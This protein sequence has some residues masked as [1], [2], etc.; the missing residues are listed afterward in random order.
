MPAI[1]TDAVAIRF[2]L[3]AAPAAFRGIDWEC[4]FTPRGLGALAIRAAGDAA[5]RFPKRRS[6]AAAAT[7]VPRAYAMRFAE[8]QRKLLDRLKGGRDDYDFE[9][10]DLSGAGAFHLRAWRAMRA[11]PFGATATYG[12]VAERAGSPLAYRAAGQACNANRIL[13]FIPCHRVLAAN[14]L[15][16]FGCGLEW[17]KKFL[18]LETPAQ[19]DVVAR[20]AAQRERASA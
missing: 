1:Q 13:L 18:A 8:L 9:D 7:D 12:E 3:P 14:G 5:S 11:I 19:S 10:F 17:K 16:G 2:S 6:A 20:T 4:A 15:G